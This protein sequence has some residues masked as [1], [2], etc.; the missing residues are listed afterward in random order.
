M[1]VLI[2]G[3]NF[4]GQPAQREHNPCCSSQFHGRALCCECYCRTH[5]VEVNKCSPEM[6]AK[7]AY[8]RANGGQS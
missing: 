5:F 2:C 6:H 8:S 4:C 7:A 3:L 1:D